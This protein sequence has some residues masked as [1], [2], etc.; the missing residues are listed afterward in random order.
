M[1]RYKETIEKWLCHEF[2]W[3]GKYTSKETMEMRLLEKLMTLLN[4]SQKDIILAYRSM[5][6]HPEC[7]LK[8]QFLLEKYGPS[9]SADMIMDTFSSDYHMP[10]KLIQFTEFLK[11]HL[12][13]Y[14]TAHIKFYL[15][16][17]YA[18]DGYGGD[19]LA[20]YVRHLRFGM[21]GKKETL[22]DPEEIHVQAV[23]YAYKMMYR[24]YPEKPLPPEKV[25]FYIDGALKR[26]GGREFG[27][28]YLE[29]V[30]PNLEKVKNFID[31][32]QT[33]RDA[34]NFDAEYY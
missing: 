1:E 10:E 32:R 18:V 27:A 2:K 26:N 16:Y 29:F 30:G 21:G 22:Q 12:K 20:H 3:C 28:Y 9:S 33:R 8:L 15:D 7:S 4:K 6:V 24:M 14:W 23:R 13:M 31:E 11:D 5:Y 25:A 17:V 34:T 19:S